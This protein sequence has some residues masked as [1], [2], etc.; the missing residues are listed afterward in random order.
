M[1]S[2]SKSVKVHL[3]DVQTPDGVRSMCGHGHGRPFDTEGDMGEIVLVKPV[4]GT[5]TKMTGEK[6]LVT[7]QSCLRSLASAAMRA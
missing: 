5:D 4:N 2:N 6:E 3:I 1:K 7:C